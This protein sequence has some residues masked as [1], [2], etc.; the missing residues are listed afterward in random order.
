MIFQNYDYENFKFSLSLAA[1]SARGK[2]LA[3]KGE[4]CERQITR[5]EKIKL[6]KSIYKQRLAEIDLPAWG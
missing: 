2:A 4:G 6:P 1:C 3:G 5:G